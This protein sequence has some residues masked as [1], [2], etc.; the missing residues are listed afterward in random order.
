MVTRGRRVFTHGDFDL[1]KYETELA[2]VLI[3]EHKNAEAAALLEE[4]VGRLTKALGAADGQTM[5]AAGLLASLRGGGR[6]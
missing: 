3:A 2:E 6:K 4:A 1:G 5:R